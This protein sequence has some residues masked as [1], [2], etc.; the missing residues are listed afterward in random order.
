MTQSVK[1]T[2]ERIKGGVIAGLFTASCAFALIPAANADTMD[3]AAATTVTETVDRTIA[4]LEDSNIT[5]AEAERIIEMVDVDKVAQFSLGNHW[6]DLSDAQK[7][8]YLDA[9]HTYAKQQL[10]EHLS[11]FS[12]ASV[13]VTDVVSRGPKDT[14][15]ETQVTTD[16]D[17]QTVSWRLID[18]G[19]VDIQVQDV[20]FAIEQ[21]AQFD[22]L[23]DQNGGDIDALIADI[24]S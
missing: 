9:F 17:R 23:L 14:I 8:D 18:G 5:D 10:R 19:I 12:Q 22:A 21:R 20:W 4:A 1:T 2:A 24:K 11:G 7:S 15:V 3:S 13:E 6:A 16:D